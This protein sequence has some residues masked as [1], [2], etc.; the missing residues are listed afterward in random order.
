MSES[1]LSGFWMLLW[2]SFR[3]TRGPV[4]TIV[5]LALGF[6]G[7]AQSSPSQTVPAWTV[8]SGGILGLTVILTLIDAVN[9]SLRAAGKKLPAV[10][11]SGK[12]PESYRDTMALLLLEPSDLFAP[13]SLVSVYRR[14]GLYEE[15]VGIGRVMSVQENRSVQV[16]VRRIV[17]T[18]PDLLPLLIGNDATVH[19]SLLVKPNVPDFEIEAGD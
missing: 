15:F 7:W 16:G 12:A 17:A 6:L 10:K 14:S 18:A 4:G 1:E 8:F 5:G 19:R 13:G 9:E 3:R 2:R 11:W